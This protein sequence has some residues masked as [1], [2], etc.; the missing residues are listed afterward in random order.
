MNRRTFVFAAMGSAVEASSADAGPAKNSRAWYELRFYHLRNDLE[1]KPLDDLLRGTYLPLCKK[2][3]VTTAGF[4]NVTIGQN[5]PTLVSLVSYPSLAMM[6]SVTDLLSEDPS[7]RKALEEFS[8]IKPMV[9]TRVHS[10]LLRAFASMPVIENAHS[11][12]AAEPRLFELR[13]YESRNLQACLTKIR[14]FEEDEIGIFRRTGL[15]PVFF[16]QTIVGDDLPNLTY[17][18][19]FQ[20][21]EARERAW[22]EFVAHPDWIKLRSKREFADS[23]IVSNISNCFLRPTAYSEIR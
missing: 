20:S 13:T 14:M 21:M 12:E 1:R 22:R 11:D 2:A 6:G 8:Q 23:E 19:S 15:N 5:M 3:G 10:R 17:L 9:Y 4:F 7:W 16:G 18:L